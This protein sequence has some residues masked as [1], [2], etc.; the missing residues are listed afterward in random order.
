[1][2]EYEMLRNEM[3]EHYKAIVTYN[4][5][6]FA[7]AATILAFSL[8]QDHFVFCLTSYVVILPA[9]FLCENEHLRICY[10]ATY[11]Y[12]FHEFDGNVF[13]WEKR[14]HLFDEH[15]TRISKRSWQTSSPH[16][17]IMIISSLFAIF[18]IINS[19][20]DVKQI[21]INI[22]LVVVLFAVSII[23]MKA[24]RVDYVKIRNKLIG[25]WLELKNIH[26]I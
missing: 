11:L 12:V 5:V 14:H 13:K 24:T 15:F 7:A 10:I 17:V 26:D 23:L 21:T 6:L 2:T 3:L 20:D 18:Q 4:N 1:M 9:Y 25:Q 19:K 22:S 16:F 8:T